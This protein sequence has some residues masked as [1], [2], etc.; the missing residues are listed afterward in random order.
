M[1]T[2]FLQLM[3]QELCFFG[4]LPVFQSLGDSLLQRD[5][6]SPL[7]ELETLG[8]ELAKLTDLG[9]M[10]SSNETGELDLAVHRGVPP[11]L[12]KRPLESRRELFRS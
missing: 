10:P 2:L 11:P 3:T 5:T 12:P 4:Q 8:V 1:E 6:N 9:L 7:A